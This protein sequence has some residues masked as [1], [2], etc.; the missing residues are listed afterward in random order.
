M[1]LL[2]ML[3]IHRLAGLA[4]SRNTALYA[5]HAVQLYRDQGF[6]CMNF[7]QRQCSKRV[8]QIE[9]CIQGMAYP[10]QWNLPYGCTKPCIFKVDKPGIQADGLLKH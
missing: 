4:D 1:A 3:K 7:V 2:H 6:S 9:I 10:I 8:R 5:V